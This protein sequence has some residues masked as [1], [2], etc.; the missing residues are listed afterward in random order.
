MREIY[1]KMGACGEF[2]DSRFSPNLGAPLVCERDSK[3]HPGRSTRTAAKKGA[4]GAANAAM[5]GGGE[6][7]FGNSD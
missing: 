4:T 5:E 7:R 6:R 3:H 1:Q 2:E